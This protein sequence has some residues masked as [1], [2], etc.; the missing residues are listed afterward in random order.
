M[1]KRGRPPV[2]RPVMNFDV[3]KFM[4]ALE[5]NIR[6]LVRQYTDATIAEV[7]DDVNAAIAVLADD[8]E[9]MAEHLGLD[10][11]TSPPQ[12]EANVHQLPVR[13]PDDRE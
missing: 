12:E 4:D 10:T 3:D 8:I 11:I 13:R 1:T 7:I 2:P 9:T 5:E 6:L